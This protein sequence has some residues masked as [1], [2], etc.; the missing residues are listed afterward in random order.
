MPEEALPAEVTTPTWENPSYG[1]AAADRCGAHRWPAP[2]FPRRQRR[3]AD[4]RQL[5]DG[6]GI[7]CDQGW[8]DWTDS[9]RDLTMAARSAGSELGMAGVPAVADDDGAEASGVSAVKFSG[10]VV[11]D[12]GCLD[13]DTRL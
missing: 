12:K 9:A 1:N 10:G 11:A 8:R 6:I 5:L 3:A 2:S 13:R 7:A 4:G